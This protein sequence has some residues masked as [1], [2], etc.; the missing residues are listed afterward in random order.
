MLY[1]V[2]TVERRRVP[3]HTGEGASAPDLEAPRGKRH[4]ESYNFV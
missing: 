3:A 1:E 2:I 4:D